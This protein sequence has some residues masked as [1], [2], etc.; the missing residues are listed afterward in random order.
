MATLKKL[1]Y[2]IINKKTKEEKLE[3]RIKTLIELIE[4]QKRSEAKK[5]EEYARNLVDDYSLDSFIVSKKDGSVLLSNDNQNAFERAVKS[6]S[7][8]EFI[9]TEYPDA[10]LLIIKTRK[11]YNVLY[12]E[13]DLVYLFKTSGDISAIE[14]KQIA[15]KIR[16]GIKN[17]NL[18]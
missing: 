8:Q 12:T 10:N 17:F 5:P 16:E 2:K 11:N 4:I 9:K 15:K 3:K 1:F 6:S 7:F 14:T 18:N 13:D